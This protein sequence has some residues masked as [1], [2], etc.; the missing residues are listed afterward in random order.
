MPEEETNAQSFLNAFADV[1]EELARQQNR[2]LPN[3]RWDRFVELVDDSDALIPQQKDALKAFG[4]L[5]NAIVHSRYRHNQPI[6]DPRDDTVEAIE[7]LRLLV[8]RP[9]LLVDALVD[10]GKPRVLSSEDD[11]KEFLGLVSDSNFSQTPVSTDS[12]HMLITTNAVARWFAHSLLQYG[13]IVETATVGHVLGYAELG[14][15]LQ[16]VN[17]LTTTV[18]AI[19][20]FSGGS[21][22]RIEPPSALLV[23]GL[24]GQPPQRLCSRTDLTS[25]Y[26][27]LGN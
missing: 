6:A 8:L 23:M 17:P 14:D 18:Q 11:I 5:R 10:R 20:I 12:G 22:E 3:N 13:G 9:P 26:A 4:K 21:S 15:R 7:K 25:L 16:K 24:P 1:E 19:N 2:R 27:Q